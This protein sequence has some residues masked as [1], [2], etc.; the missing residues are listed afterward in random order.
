[1]V[2][3]DALVEHV[4]LDLLSSLSL[5]LVKGVVPIHLSLSQLL[6]L[7][8]V[9]LNI[10]YGLIQST[11]VLC[12]LQGRSL[13]ELRLIPEVFSVPDAGLVVSLS[14]DDTHWCL[15]QVV[16][17]R[18]LLFGYFLDSLPVNRSL[19]ALEV[20]LL[21][22]SRSEVEFLQCHI[23]VLVHND[24]RVEEH[25]L[26][27]GLS[28]LGNPSKQSLRVVNELACQILLHVCD[29]GLVSLERDN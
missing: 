12:E 9:L 28:L 5:V 19:L 8:V 26:S 16:V 29:C 4:V 27:D 6:V 17:G 3:H 15:G 24:I 21:H 25:Q 14:V 1:L 20:D 10:C 2:A 18:L 7:Y 13:L 23:R 11:Q 22:G